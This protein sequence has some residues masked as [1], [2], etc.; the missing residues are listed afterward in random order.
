MPP[1]KSNPSVI[2]PG[3]A[4]IGHGDTPAPDDEQA[5]YP[6]DKGLFLRALDVGTQVV[7]RSPQ[8][9]IVVCR[10]FRRFVVTVSVLSHVVVCLNDM[11]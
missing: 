4:S 11:S 10:T 2:G 7:G 8:R 9:A 1:N 3:N 5:W 6:V